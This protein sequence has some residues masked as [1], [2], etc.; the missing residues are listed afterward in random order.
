MYID[1]Y[2]FCFRNSCVM[3][4]AILLLVTAGLKSSPGAEL[5]GMLIMG[6]RH[7]INKD[8]SGVF[9]VFR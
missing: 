4:L 1:I 3:F 8:Y 7:R 5:I 2:A 9:Y 6:K